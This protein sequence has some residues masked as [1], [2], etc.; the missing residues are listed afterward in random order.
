M[1]APKLTLIGAGPGDPDLLTIKGMKALE[2]ADVVLYDALCNTALLN[3]APADCPKIFVGKRAGHH[4][5]DQ[6][7]INALILKLSKS[8]QHIV[9][10][11]GGDPL[12]FGRGFEELIVAQQAQITFEVIPGVSCINGVTGSNI[13]PLTHRG[14]VRS[15]TVVTGTT[16]RGLISEDLNHAAK[17]S[18]TVAVLM[19]IKKLAEII[20]IFKAAREDCPIAIIENGSL[21]NQRILRGQLSTIVELATKENIQNP[22]LIVIGEVVALQDMLTTPEVLRLSEAG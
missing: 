7:A 1:T 9:R 12:V 8:H 17:G 18:G 2:S 14:L 19:G 15:F 13:I 6:Q 21:P 4:S 5:L 11:K 3:Y 22:A 16:C 10:L 20:A